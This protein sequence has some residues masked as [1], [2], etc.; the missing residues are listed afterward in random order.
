MLS[1]ILDMFSWVTFYFSMQKHDSTPPPRYELA[2]E[3][4]VIYTTLK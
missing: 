1:L 4:L 2:A 3:S